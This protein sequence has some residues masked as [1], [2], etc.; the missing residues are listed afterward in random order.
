MDEKATMIR[1][2]EG[3]YWLQTRDSAGRLRSSYLGNVGPASQVQTWCIGHGIRFSQVNASN[4][5]R[6]HGAAASST[7]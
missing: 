1:D 7:R 4:G 2:Q 6:G 3:F 5:Q